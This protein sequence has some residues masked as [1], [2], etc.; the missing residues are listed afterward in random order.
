[1][2]K[3]PVTATVIGSGPNG[4]SAA[5]VLASA[6][7][8]TSVFERNSQIGGACSTAET[9]LPDFRQ[10]LGSSVYPI[11]AASPFF[12]SLPINIPWIE[13]TSP[14]AHPLDDGTAVMLEHSIE[15]TVATLDLRDAD[16]YRSLIAPLASKFAELSEDILGPIQHIPRHPFVLAPFASSALLSAVSLARS[17]FSGKRAQ[18]FF[19]GMAT[20][21]VLP[22]EA[23]AS[24]AVGL[25]LIAAGHA[26]G[27]PILRGGAQALADA[28]ARHLEGLGGRIEI[29]REVTQLPES[30]LILADI[31]PRQLLRIAGSQLPPLY[32]RRLERFRYGPGAFKIDYALSAPI[33]WTARECSRAAT[34]HIGGSLDEIV[35]S[36]RTL[37][38]DK[39]FVLV[40]QPSLFDLSRAPVGK[41]T[42]W[43]YCHVPNGSTKDYTELIE[44]QVTRFAPDFRDCILARSI[45]S[46][47]TLERWNPNLIGGDFLGGAMD[48]RQ[49]LFRPTSSLYRT[50]RSNLY[51]CGASTP[52]GG[53]VHGMSGY[54]AATTALERLMR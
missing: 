50:P 54:H 30:D 51:L 10:D 35:E 28:L 45:S 19:A 8:N 37:S 33:P 4:L 17:R 49:L 3:K 26:S 15:A 39:P 14:C 9:T 1:M 27:W 46:P 36:E 6:G 31:T 41:H 34:V 18:A 40:G 7:L 5:I 43:A 25:T 29:D 42:A 38:C 13:P 12:R 2:V 21:S 23:P 48:L 44:G 20:H 22:L 52:P 16:R 24:A 53:G 32:R 11:G 47:M